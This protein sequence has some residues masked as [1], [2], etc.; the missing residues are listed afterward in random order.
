MVLWLTA[1]SALA[2]DAA[3]AAPNPHAGAAISAQCAICHGSNG[4]SVAANIPNIA[5]QRF[6]Y[7]VARMKAFKNGTVQSAT[8]NEMAR[9]LSEEQ[10]EDL[11]AY[12]ASVPLRVGSPGHA[13]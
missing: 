10:I 11:S 12:Y 6:P 9:S 3:V 2:A 1:V 7:L 13:R 5:G 4:I 8:M